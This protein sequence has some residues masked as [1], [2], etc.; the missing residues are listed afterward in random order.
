MGR[1]RKKK[2]AR[3]GDEIG[4]AQE[5]KTMVDGNDEEDYFRAMWFESQRSGEQPCW[6]IPVVKCGGNVSSL[7]ENS[8]S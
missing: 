5:E 2:I 1:K 8:G 7:C 4:S 3:V 6:F